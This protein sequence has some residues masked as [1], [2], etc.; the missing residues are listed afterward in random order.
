MNVL[1]KRNTHIEF[2]ST[3][4][5]LRV[6][7]RVVLCL[8][9]ATAATGFLASCASAPG[10]GTWLETG[11]K[12]VCLT[13][14]AYA[15][16]CAA[17]GDRSERCVEA[18]VLASACSIGAPVAGELGQGV[19]A[20][21]LPPV[22]LSPGAGYHPRTLATFWR[23]FPGG[24]E[25]SGV[26]DPSTDPWALA[27]VAKAGQEWQ[28]CLRSRYLT[29]SPDV[30]AAY[31]R[32]F[33]VTTCGSPGGGWTRGPSNERWG[34]ARQAL[35]YFCEND[36]AVI[37][38]SGRAGGWDCQS[39][40]VEWARLGAFGG[41]AVVTEWQRRTAGPPPPPAPRCG[42]RH[43]DPGETCTNC[44]ADIGPCAPHP[45]PD[46]RLDCT[47]LAI[48]APEAPRF[49]GVKAGVESTGLAGYRLL[50]CRGGSLPSLEPARPEPSAET[51]RWLA[52]ICPSLPRNWTA[53]RAKCAAAVSELLGV[54]QLEVTP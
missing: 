16:S 2:G 1:E 47:G 28:A 13:A 41:E 54:E 51:R 14:R 20:A 31:R 29:E 24:P 52:E 8:L 48:P 50:E 21:A 32:A 23:D 43:P 39:T 35:D 11:S 49:V 38:S 18:E 26:G 45:P 5:D 4:V 30:C 36:P 25:R 12:A 37:G 22:T 17:R 34:S 53:R 9:L 44:P 40:A 15:A 46:P 6:I 19:M 33:G 3:S 42:D 7:L 27:C 10:G